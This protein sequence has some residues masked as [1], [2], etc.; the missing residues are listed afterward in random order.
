MTNRVLIIRCFHSRQGDIH[1]L[2][3]TY[4]GH[5]LNTTSYKQINNF[6]PVDKMKEFVKNIAS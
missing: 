4:I 3:P 2:P 1:A 6:F 5:Q